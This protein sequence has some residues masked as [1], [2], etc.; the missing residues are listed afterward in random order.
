MPVNESGGQTRSLASSSSFVPSP[1]PCPVVAHRPK[2]F[3]VTTQQAEMVEHL[4]EHGYA[5]VAAVAD[6]D[7]ITH[8]KA[9]MW[10]FM[11][12]AMPGSNVDR[13]TPDSWD[14]PGWVASSSTGIVQGCGFG[15]SEFAWSIRLLPKVKA[16]NSQRF[17][18]LTICW[19]RLCVRLLPI[20]AP[21]NSVLKLH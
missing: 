11:E 14:G 3:D 16:A 15:Q 12:G 5:V 6:P 9:L 17:G 19:S 18:K 1:C 10:D 20:R 2:R 13:H 21:L 8:S 4:R 7:Q